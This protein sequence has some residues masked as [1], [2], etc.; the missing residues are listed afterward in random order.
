MLW[1]RQ[2]I[3]SKPATLPPKAVVTYSTSTP[4]ESPPP[5][6]SEYKVAA[7]QPK[8]II[9]PSLNIEAYIQKVG[10]DQHGDVSVPSNINFAGWFVN[11]VKPGENGLSLVDGHVG[12]RYNKGAFK[13]LIKLQIGSQVNIEYGDGSL[14]KFEV[15]DKRELAA[16]KAA[17][18]LFE[19]QKDINAQLN[20]ITCSGDFDKK[21]N[22][23]N[24]RTI[25]VSKRITS[26]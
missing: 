7:D 25:V 12:G 14:R 4:D 6:A 23:F 11:S 18:F 9:I 21:T 13:D 26:S 1:Q 5:K 22:T 20:L 15:T 17:P 10:V 3:I 16:D 24:K 8:T 19:K 2:S